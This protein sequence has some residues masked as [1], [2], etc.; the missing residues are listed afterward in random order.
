MCYVFI[1]I[2]LTVMCN[3][4]AIFIVIFK[5]LETFDYVPSFHSRLKIGEQGFSHLYT[6]RIT[7]M[8]IFWCLAIQYK[9][10]VLVETYFIN[11]SELILISFEPDVVYFL[12]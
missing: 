4:L 1:S 5:R 11:D 2:S 6:L 8:C 3:F 9:T 10:S 7:I 12:S